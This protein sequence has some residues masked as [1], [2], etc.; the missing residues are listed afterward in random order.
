MKTKLCISM[1]IKTVISI[2]GILLITMILMF[3]VGTPVWLFSLNVVNI[4]ILYT[5]SIKSDI[6]AVNDHV[7]NLLDAISITSNLDQEE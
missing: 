6:D 2:V 4:F 3:Y 5:L 7:E 1:D